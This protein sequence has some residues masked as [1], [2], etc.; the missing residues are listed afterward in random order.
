MID[1]ASLKQ[2]EIAEALIRKLRNESGSAG[3]RLDNLGG[4]GALERYQEGK[5][6][7]APY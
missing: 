4:T 2:S 3:T 1:P 5:T 7:L 6:L